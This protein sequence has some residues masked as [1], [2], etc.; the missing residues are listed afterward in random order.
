MPFK[1][2]EIKSNMQAGRLFFC[3]FLFF[4]I[5]GCGT[6]RRDGQELDFVGAGNQKYAASEGSTRSQLREQEEPRRPLVIDLINDLVFRYRRDGWTLTTKHAQVNLDKLKSAGVDLV[7]S[8]LPV[9]PGQDPMAALNAALR[10]MEKIVAD[11]GGGVEVVSSFRDALAARNRGVVPMMLLLEGADAFVGRLDK[12]AEFKHR[13]LKMIGLVSNRGNRFADSAVAPAEESGITASGLDLLRICRDLGLVVDLTH[14]S[15]DT[16]WDVLKVQAG[17]VVVS[18]TAARA[19][20]DH[21]R[22]LNDLQILAL[23]RYGGLMG[24]VFNPDFLR[25]RS[26]G[27]ARLDDVV[28]HIMHVK[29][30]GSIGSLAI[31]S[32]FNGIHPPVG[33]SDISQLPAL[34]QALKQQGLIDEEIAGFMGG[35]ARRVLEES[36]RSHGSVKFV[37]DEILRPIDIECDVVIG[38]YEG[39]AS[40]ACNKYLLDKGP[41]LPPQSRHK[42]RIRDMTR[43]PARLELFGEPRTPW[44]VEGQ[45]LEGKTLFNRIVALDEAGRGRLSLPSDRNLTRIFCSPTRTSTLSEIVVWGH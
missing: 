15:P 31:G 18:H 25:S 29:R 45:N 41:V 36:E 38:E 8:A 24:L 5:G 17:T 2:V 3:A 33:L 42:A 14:A 37:E 43:R 39:T 16:F 32:D 27:R 11:A 28:A 22:N 12:V 4:L 35:N 19:L 1:I 20:R 26:A 34:R 44:Q 9:P 23:R 30:V 21:P 40:L 13:G 7:F 10:D 6:D